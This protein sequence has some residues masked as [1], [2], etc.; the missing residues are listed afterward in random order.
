MGDSIMVVFGG[1][2][3]LEDD[4]KRALLCAIDLQ[5][6]MD[7]LNEHFKQFD[8]P[9]L[10]LGIGVNTGPV[11]A[12]TLGSDLYAAYTIMGDEVNL[13]SRIEAFSLRG[14]VLIS[15]NTYKRCNDFVTTGEPIT[16]Q[17]KGKTDS[18][19]LREVLEIPSHGKIV[20]RREIRRSPRV[21]LNMPFS[22]QVIENAVALPQV[23]R[24]VV[25]D[26][27][28]FGVMAGIDQPF[29]LLTELKIELDLTLV[30]SKATDIYAK[31][32]K[33]IESDKG[34]SCGL[35]F[36]SLSAQ[37]S[38]DIQRLVHLLIQGSEST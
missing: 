13:A 24:G 27:G 25:L 7:E 8:L 31:V 29:A 23:H 36:T 9:E 18:I 12:G 28:Y 16:V 1:Q 38:R 32:V 19:T 30:S 21:K 11:L 34:Y 15:E 37:H 5:L 3:S 17:I 6:A 10:Y 2:L 33:V 22:Y 14:Q 20:P 4:V 35:E 26:I